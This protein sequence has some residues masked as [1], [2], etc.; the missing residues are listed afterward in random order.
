MCEEARSILRCALL[1]ND[2]GKDLWLDYFQGHV[3]IQTDL[4]VGL[5][6]SFLIEVSGYLLVD[7]KRGFCHTEGAKWR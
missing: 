4:S 6:N 5:W 2:I 3:L 7:S 1:T